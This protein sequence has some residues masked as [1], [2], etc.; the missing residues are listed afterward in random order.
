MLGKAYLTMMGPERAVLGRELRRAVVKAP[1]GFE[2]IQVFVNRMLIEIWMIK[3]ILL[4]SQTE[5]RNIFLAGKTIL[6]IKWERA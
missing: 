5:M 2:N 6:V 1:V 3:F 4:S